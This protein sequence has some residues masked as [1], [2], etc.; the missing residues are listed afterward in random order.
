MKKR[1]ESGF[2][3]LLVFL[4]AATIAITLYLEIPRVAFQAQRQ[5]EQLLIERGEQYKRAIQLFVRVN[6]RYPGDLKDLENFNN[7]RFLRHK[8][9]D[10]MTGKDDWRIVHIN[11]GVLTDSVLNKQKPGDTGQ[12]AASTA[13]QYVGEQ[14]GIGTALT[15]AQQNLNA[16]VTRRRASEGGIAPT[17]GP[18]GQPLMPGQPLPGQPVT[19]ITPIPGQSNPNQPAPGQVFPTQPGAG[20]PIGQP[21]PGQPQTQSFPGQILPGQVPGQP[22]PGGPTNFGQAQPFPG[23]QPGTQPYTG[24]LPMQPTP[25]TPIP[26]ELTNPGGVNP[27]GQPIPGRLGAFAPPGVTGNPNPSGQTSGPTYV[28]GSQPYVG[29]S[30]PYVGGGQY[31]GSQPA[32]TPG[33]PQPGP[34]TPTPVNPAA[35][36]Q[37]N[38]PA[39][40]VPQ[41]FGTPLPAGNSQPFGT[42]QPG[43]TPQPFGTPQTTTPGV[44]GQ[45]PATDMINNILRNPRPVQAGAPLGGQ[46]IGGGIAGIASK[47][48]NAAIMVYNDRTNYNQWEF[49]FDYTK[50]A[51][52]PNPSGGTIGTSAATLGSVAGN[53]S[54]GATPSPTGAL[55]TTGFGASPTPGP[56]GQSPFGQPQGQNPS[57]PP[58]GQGAAGMP[59]LPPGL[60]PGRP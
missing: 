47:S 52:L 13:G 14:A 4:M 18:D 53:P 10:P 8:F 2:A 12:Q 32:P 34:F 46:Q 38:F 59:Q 15:P 7:R 41:P 5:K 40:G 6:G 11:N 54:P 44:A 16:G 9:I 1:G 22:Y 33:T 24:Q 37:P 35:P 57:A 36:T 19:G 26:P 23:A 17:V 50:Q 39:G 56:Q 43:G 3:M 49:I 51:P 30:Q 45:S 31:I 58:T 28:G 29:G 42:Q 25:G 48:E 55:G 21:Y 20:Q 60:R 27:A